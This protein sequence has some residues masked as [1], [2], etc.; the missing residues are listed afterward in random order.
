VGI[1]L[2]LPARIPVTPQRITPAE[3]ALVL[4]LLDGAE[5]APVPG[6]GW[7]APGSSSEPALREL[8]TAPEQMDET[9]PARD[10]TVGPDE[11]LLAEVHPLPSRPPRL[12]ILGGVALHDTTGPAPVSFGADPSSG[13]PQTA[14]ATELVGYLTFHREGTTLRALADALFPGH[15]LRLD[16]TAKL[17]TRTRRWLGV[18]SDGTAWLPRVQGDGPIALAPE[19]LTDWDELRALIGGSLA[20]A[21]ADRLSAAME[22]V[23]GAPFAGTPQGSWA[24]AEPF[25]ED[26]LAAML[27]L[28]HEVADRAIRT[29]DSATA[30]RA[31]SLGRELDPDNELMWRDALRAEYV[32]GDPAEQARLT[33][34]LLA[35]SDDLQVDL[36]PATAG[37]IDELQRAAGQ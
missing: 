16:R 14:R 35:Q 27:D 13:A 6:P 30:R 17:L 12:T 26:I 3:L 15:D 4:T 7:S 2:L 25:K 8:P 33:E 29:G 19:V 37:L 9:A 10:I 21:P 32:A 18:R 31:S 1:G 28:L 23:A 5:R 34:Q 20:L 36:D 11:A 24:W 22:L